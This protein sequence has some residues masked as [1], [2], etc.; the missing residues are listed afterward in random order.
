[1]ALKIRKNPVASPPYCPITEC[2]AVLGGAWTT[3]ILWHL[4]ATPRRFGELRIDMPQISA[5]TLSARLRTLE[6]HGVLTRTIMPTSPPSTEYALTELGRDLM[7]VLRSIAEAGLKL[8]ARRLGHD[9]AECD[10][11]G[12]PKA[13]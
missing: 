13:A 10:I 2:M 6:Q 5:K 4:Q 9:A 12:V 3:H 8:K 1:M 11:P 7:P